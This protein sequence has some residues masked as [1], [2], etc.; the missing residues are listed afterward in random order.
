MP[1]DKRFKIFSEFY[2]IAVS[3]TWIFHAV[4]AISNRQPNK[5]NVKKTCGR[6]NPIGVE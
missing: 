5:I 6:E 4:R 3:D 1:K 2:T